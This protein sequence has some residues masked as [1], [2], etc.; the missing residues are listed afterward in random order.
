MD[1]DGRS[2][3]GIGRIMGYET[4]TER[5]WL[6]AYQQQHSAGLVDRPRKGRPPIKRCLTARVQAQASQSPACSGYLRACWTVALW[7][8]HLAHLQWVSTQPGRKGLVG[9]Q[10]RDCGP[11][12]FP[13]PPGVGCG[14]PPSLCQVFSDPSAG[15]S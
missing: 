6:K 12:L 3:V 11:S 5:A 4:Q 15:L 9:A 1:A 13:L 2:P 10:R 7:G 8:L 14:D